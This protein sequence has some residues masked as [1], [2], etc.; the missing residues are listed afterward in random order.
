MFPF[1]TGLWTC[2]QYH[3]SPLAYR[4]FL[5]YCLM[6]IPVSIQFC[7]HFCQSHFVEVFVQWSAVL[8]PR[9]HT[10]YMGKHFH[11]LFE[12]RSPR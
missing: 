12:F 11:K 5:T 9:D 1:F 3:H 2:S 10:D 4:F 8:G 7:T 6:A